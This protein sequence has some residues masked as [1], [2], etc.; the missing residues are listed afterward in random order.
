MLAIRTA[1]IAALML[2]ASTLL[3]LAEPVPP[4]DEGA[5]NP[6]FAAFRSELI[7]IVEA[8]DLARLEPILH[9]DIRISFGTGGGRAD[10]VAEFQANPER[11]DKLGELLALGGK[12]EEPSRFVAPYTFHVE[13]DDPYSTAVVTAQNLNVRAQPSTTAPVLT[14]LSYE[15]VT[16][17]ENALGTEGWFKIELPDGRAGYVSADF[18]RLILDYRASFVLTDGAWLMDFFLAGD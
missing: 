14:Q 7:A 2:A 13:V 12:F 10:A 8:R 1:A 4:V 6:S 5:A 3:A 16:L 18:A 17:G 11:W 9:P 15:T